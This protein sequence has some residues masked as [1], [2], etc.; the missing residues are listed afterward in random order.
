MLTMRYTK[1]MLNCLNNVNLY[2]A[3]YKLPP[4][5]ARVDES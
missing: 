4:L 2:K 1:Q 3:F 5:I